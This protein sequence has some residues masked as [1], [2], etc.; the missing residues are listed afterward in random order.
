MMWLG[1]KNHVD[2]KDLSPDIKE[3]KSSR[4]AL[5][6]IGSRGKITYD[7]MQAEIVQP[8]IAAWGLPVEL[9]IPSDGDSSHVL[10]LWAQQKDIPVTMISSDWLTHGRRA[11]MIRD[12]SI[13]K[14]ASR[15]VFLQGPRSNAIAATANRLAKKGRL[16]ALSERPG[17]SLT[18]LCQK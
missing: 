15:L 4:Y 1:S 8:M 12:I 7:A 3:P 16:V 17:H 5:G 2:E 13:Q 11:S 18:I 10:M 6:I 9:I 14:A